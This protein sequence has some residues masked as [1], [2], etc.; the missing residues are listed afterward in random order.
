MPKKKTVSPAKAKEILRDGT[1][2]GKKLTK[3]QKGY[4]G[5]IAGGKKPKK[6]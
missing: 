1:A 5:V 4:F 6:K 2:H 3:K